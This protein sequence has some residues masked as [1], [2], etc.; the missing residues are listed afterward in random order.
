MEELLG[1]IVVHVM[2]GLTVERLVQCAEPETPVV[3]QYYKERSCGMKILAI[4]GIFLF[5][6][7][8]VAGARNFQGI[9][10]GSDDRAVFFAQRVW[11]AGTNT[12]ASLIR[13][14][15]ENLKSRTAGYAPAEIEQKLICYARLLNAVD[16]EWQRLR[17]EQN[18]LRQELAGI[19]LE[20]MFFGVID[21]DLLKKLDDPMVFFQNR[22]LGKSESELLPLVKECNDVIC[23]VSSDLR[24]E[25]L[26]QKDDRDNEK[27]KMVALMKQLDERWVTFRSG[28]VVDGRPLFKDV[29][30]EDNSF[31]CKSLRM[32][33]MSVETYTKFFVALFTT[34][35]TENLEFIESKCTEISR[36]FSKW[37]M[38]DIHRYEN[39]LEVLCDAYEKQAEMV[40]ILQPLRDKVDK[41]LSTGS[42]VP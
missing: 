22:Y 16:A 10:N 2:R 24:T 9:G 20:G 26:G 14:E 41:G 13:Q 18:Y 31:F 25:L 36:I 11:F 21:A 12:I 23:R 28:L 42:S 19:K 5:S 40:A 33:E 29:G 6:F 15:T 7:C 3:P 1:I 17:K 8:T 37:I 4:I 39:R 32:N 34:D 27:I 35:Q 30:E 38:A